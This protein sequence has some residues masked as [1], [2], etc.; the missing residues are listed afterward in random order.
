MHSDFNSY[1]RHIIWRYKYLN[2]R[3]EQ[4]NK[5]DKEIVEKFL[6]GVQI[7]HRKEKYEAGIYIKDI[8]NVVAFNTVKEEYY[9]NEDNNDENN[10][11][12]KKEKQPQ[13]EEKKTRKNQ[14]LLAAD[15]IRKLE[16]KKE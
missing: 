13:K 4:M 6:N 3:P 8:E 14:I 2:I 15:E 11:E 12:I 1:D 10:T 16:N 5:K 7:L 9:E